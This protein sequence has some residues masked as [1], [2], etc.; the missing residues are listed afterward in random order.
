MWGGLPNAGLECGAPDLHF[1]S[2]VQVMQMTVKRRGGRE[3]VQ[4]SPKD[5]SPTTRGTEGLHWRCP[6]TIMHWHLWVPS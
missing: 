6:I 3:N 4:G 2:V 1:Y 5:S